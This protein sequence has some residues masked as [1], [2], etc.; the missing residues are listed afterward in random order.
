MLLALS[1]DCFSLYLRTC[2]LA[3]G[4]RSLL[5]DIWMRASLSKSDN[6]LSSGT[7]ANTSRL[8]RHHSIDDDCPMIP[9]VAAAP[10]ALPVPIDAKEIRVHF[11]SDPVS[12]DHRVPLLNGNTHAASVQ[13]Q[14]SSF[15][16]EL[17]VRSNS[18][19]GIFTF[20]SFS[21]KLCNG[22]L[23]S[24]IDEKKFFYAN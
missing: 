10:T 2:H 24:M 16:S 21:R 23:I 3:V 5:I 12:F 19:I 18:C 8:K 4:R 20:V 22:F 17:M 7:N 6:A 14:T 9:S 11:H 1:I 13:M 15:S